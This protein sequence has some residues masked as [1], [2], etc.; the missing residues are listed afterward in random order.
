MVTLVCWGIP[1][2]VSLAVAWPRRGAVIRASHLLS[3]LSQRRQNDSCPFVS[4]YMHVML[5]YTP[6]L[7]A[8]VQTHCKKRLIGSVHGAEAQDAFF[9]LILEGSR[10][11]EGGCDL[12]TVARDLS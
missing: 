2:A 9:P 3:V 5:A 12:H 1:V 6:V 10:E 4:V 11:W 8:H 7:F